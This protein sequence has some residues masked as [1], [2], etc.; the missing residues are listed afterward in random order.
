MAG[1]AG[2][3]LQA[4]LD[5][6]CN[7]R[8]PYRRGCAL[9]RRKSLSIPTDT[10]D[11]NRSKGSR[12]QSAVPGRAGMAHDD[13]IGASCCAARTARLEFP[14]GSRFRGRSRGSVR[15]SGGGTEPL[16]AS[17]AGF[18]PGRDECAPERRPG[19]GVEGRQSCRRCGLVH[20]SIGGPGPLPGSKGAFPPGRD[21]LARRRRRARPGPGATGRGGATWVEYS[22][23]GGRCQ[24]ERRASPARWRLCWAQWSAAWCGG[25]RGRRC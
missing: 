25:G 20:P 3:N 6:V 14:M 7:A 13:A 5:S 21:G 24:R 18:P 11:G 12:R 15:P 19:A 9:G 1:G 8:S 10:L 16:P 22:A 17:R 23:L 4:G 2:N